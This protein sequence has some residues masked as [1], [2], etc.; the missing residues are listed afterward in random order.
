[1]SPIAMRINFHKTT[2]EDELRDEAWE[3]GS[4]KTKNEEPA[5]ELRMDTREDKNW[6]VSKTINFKL[7]CC[8]L[9]LLINLKEGVEIQLP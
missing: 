3:G 6:F 9:S 4:G 1:M 5:D 8:E 2:H 7:L